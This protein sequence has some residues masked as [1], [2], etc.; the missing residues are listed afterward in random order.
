MR[1]ATILLAAMAV[2]VSAGWAQANPVA[3]PGAGFLTKKKQKSQDFYIVHKGDTDQCTVQS[4]KWENKPSGAIG[5]PY[6][7]KE[8]A[9]A[10][11]K[12]LP[13]CKGGESEESSSGKKKKNK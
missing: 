5:T 3:E 11:L 4:G 13:Q 1:I 8:Y 10:A 7:S 2:L 9:R 12:A 6:A